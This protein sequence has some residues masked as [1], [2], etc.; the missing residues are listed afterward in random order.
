MAWNYPFLYEKKNLHQFAHLIIESTL[1]KCYFLHFAGTWPESNFW[2]T[3]KLFNKKKKINLFNNLNK[4]LRMK[5]RGK[6]VGM[7]KFNS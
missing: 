7:K 6:P 1:L 5:V 3:N 2:R 4:Y